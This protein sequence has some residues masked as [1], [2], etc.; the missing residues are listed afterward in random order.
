MGSQVC[1]AHRGHPTR[2]T[3]NTSRLKTGLTQRQIQ[4]G[5]S[6]TYKWK[7]T[8]AG[9]YWY[10]AHERGQLDDGLYGP[11]VIHPKSG[12]EK[13]FGKISSDAGT[14]KAIEKAEANVQPILFSDFRHVSWVEG[15]NLQVASGI[16][17]PCYDSFLINGKGSV[18][19]MS[20]EKI[21]SL[22]RP[23]QEG[24]L[25]LINGTGFTAKGRV[26]RLSSSGRSSITNSH[27]AAS[28]PP[29]SQLYLPRTFPRTSLQSLRAYLT[30]V[31]PVKATSKLST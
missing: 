28:L 20:S 6:F 2:G 17:T 30:S 26:L 11:I 24:I 23:S 1:C 14:L 19:C 8:Q 10:H 4:A 3:W 16:E 13:P 25:Q 18:D 22:L 31:R 15:W 27:A 7:A 21:T 29:I 5:G 9:A 12:V